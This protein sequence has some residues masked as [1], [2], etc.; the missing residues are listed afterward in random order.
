MATGTRVRGLT[1]KVVSAPSRTKGCADVGGRRMTFAIAP[2]TR[3][4]IRRLAHVFEHESAH[5]KG[6][7]HENMAR[8]SLTLLYSPDAGPTPM[9]A[10]GL[11]LRWRQRAPRQL[12][13]LQQDQLTRR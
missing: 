5:I 2:P 10:R 6:M 1:I 3:L 7:Q 13:Y 9:W 4:S 11:R 8:K 12:R